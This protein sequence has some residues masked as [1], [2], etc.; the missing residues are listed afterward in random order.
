MN[1]VKEGENCLISYILHEISGMNARKWRVCEKGN[2]S[3]AS[4]AHP[5]P[6]CVA[7]AV[8][9]S[10]MNL[11]NEP[12]SLSISLRRSPDGFPPPPGLM[13]SHKKSW[14]HTCNK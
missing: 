5:E 9:N 1:K 11:S 8:L 4:Q 12:K 10:S 7:A 3:H 6:N 2:Y 14:F 13:D